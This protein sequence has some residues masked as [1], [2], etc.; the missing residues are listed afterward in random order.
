MI[1]FQATIGINL[2][3]DELIMIEYGV[4]SVIVFI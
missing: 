3:K 4:F 2:V 1:F